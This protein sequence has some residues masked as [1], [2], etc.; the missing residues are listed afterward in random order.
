MKNESLLIIIFILTIGLNYE[1][2]VK[3]FGYFLDGGD[4]KKAKLE[5]LSNQETTDIFFNFYGVEIWGVSLVENWIAEAKNYNIRVHIWLDSYN[6]G[7]WYYNYR[8]TIRLNRYIKSVQSYVKISGISG[9]LL[10]EK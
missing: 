9:I 10:L 1:A 8:N 4:I 5:S 3:G 2:D 6:N 7:D